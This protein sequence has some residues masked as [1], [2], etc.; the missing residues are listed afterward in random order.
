M[1]AWQRRREGRGECGQRVA[2]G[3][4]RGGARWAARGG[5]VG[6]RSAAGR[7]G[8]GAG[9]GGDAGDDGGVDEDDDAAIEQFAD[10]DAPARVGAA[11]R[12]ARDLQEARAD[13]HRVVA[14]HDPGVS[15]RPLD[16]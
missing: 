1:S 10:V 4:G 5:A 9:G 13:A 15:R 2:Q 3:P 12:P 8:K 14:G 11:G 16:C 7:E 6:R